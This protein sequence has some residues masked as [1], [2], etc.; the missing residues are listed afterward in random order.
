MKGWRP[1]LTRVSTRSPFTFR[2]EQYW[3]YSTH[4]TKHKIRIIF[5]KSMKKICLHLHSRTLPNTETNYIYFCTWT[6]DSPPCRRRAAGTFA[7]QPRGSSC[8]SPA[9]TWRWSTV[10]PRPPPSTRTLPLLRQEHTRRQRRHWVPS[11]QQNFRRRM[12]C[13]VLGTGSGSI[14]HLKDLLRLR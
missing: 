9:S 11:F 4:N 7:W 8:W 12:S 10:R 2:S 13:K 3:V 1:Y 5:S 6:L 14:R